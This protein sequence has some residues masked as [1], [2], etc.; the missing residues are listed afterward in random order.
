[1][2]RNCAGNTLQPGFLDAGIQSHL[3][4]EAA[5]GPRDVQAVVFC[6]IL[7]DEG[8]PQLAELRHDILRR[9]AGKVI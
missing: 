4:A 1:M 3:N 8:Q 2:S 5:L 7:H 6:R 9:A